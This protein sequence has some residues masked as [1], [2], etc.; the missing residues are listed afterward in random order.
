MS[1][2]PRAVFTGIGVFTPI[3]LGAM[4]FWDALRAGRCGIRR[5][6]TFDTSGLPIHIGAEIT[7][8]DAKDY[9]EKKDR[10]SLK[11]MARQI[12]MAVAAAPVAMT[13]AGIEP[14]KLEPTR[15]GVEFGSGL[16]ASELEELAHPAQLSIDDARQIDLSKWGR[17]GIPAMPPLWLLKYLP[18][19]LACHVSIMHNAQG[20]NNTITETDA[21]PLLAIGEAYRIITRGLA[22]VMLCGGADS[23][24]N[25]LSL[26]R[27]SLYA[28]LSKRN[29]APEKA[30]RPF[31]KHRDGLVAGEGAGILVLEELEH[32]KKRG[33]RI[34]AEVV[35]FGSAFDLHTN[36]NGLARAIRAALREADIGPESIDHINAHGFSTPT[37]DAW[38]AKG[39]Q[40]V[41]GTVKP[42]VPVFAGKSYF[43]SLGAAGGAIELAA[44]LLALQHGVVPATLNYVTPDPACPV[45]VLTRPREVTK[46]YA[47]KV[48]ITEMG[49]CAAMV[50]RKWKE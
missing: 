17:Q 28:T 39:I 2:R 31:D 8:F 6:G 49:Q 29:D 38:E 47:L 42:P 21:G 41:F 33:A 11:M 3:G 36:G 37:E 13:D 35:G 5:I 34:Y 27:A 40:Q 43:G 23:K 32:A 7:D 9:V 44:S 30:S 4:P 24:M 12:Q 45:A 26:T 16:I 15:F 46:D 25:P 10:K 48:S 1:K 22:D 20:P 19:M 50:V 18:N 14:A